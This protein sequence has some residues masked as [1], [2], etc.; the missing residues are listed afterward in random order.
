MRCKT[1]PSTFTSQTKCL[2]ET[3]GVTTVREVRLCADCK[4]KDW[5]TIDVD[6]PMRTETPLQAQEA[7]WESI[8]EFRVIASQMETMPAAF[9]PE[10]RDNFRRM[11]RMSAA[12]AMEEASRA[13]TQ[14][15]AE[16]EEFVRAQFGG[17]P[18]PGVLDVMLED[19]EFKKQYEA[20]TK[21]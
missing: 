8:R 17:P 20:H 10:I 9:K 5:P 21:K 19:P 6:A 13:H 1:A 11:F 7:N 15:P 2:S 4:G 3:P 14:V 18:Y 12:Q 16:V